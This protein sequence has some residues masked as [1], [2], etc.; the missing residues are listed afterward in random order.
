MVERPLR[1]VRRLFVPTTYVRYFRKREPCPYE[2][3]VIL[4]A[5][6]FRQR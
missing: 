2:A 6:E 3:G 4:G 1:R 5:L